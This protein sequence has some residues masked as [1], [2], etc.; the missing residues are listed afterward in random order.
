MEMSLILIAASVPFNLYSIY[1][2]TTS[3]PGGGLALLTGITLYVVGAFGV[4][5]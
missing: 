5:R 4:F 2:T 1:A 3:K